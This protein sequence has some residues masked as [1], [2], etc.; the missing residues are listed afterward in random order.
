[1]KI[2]ELIRD[3]EHMMAEHGDL[4]VEKSTWDGSRRASMLPTIDHRAVLKGRESKPRFLS[5]FYGADRN[6]REGD[7]VCR[8]P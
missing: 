8:L 7:K 2:S 1:M 3:L 4:D 6:G 5:E